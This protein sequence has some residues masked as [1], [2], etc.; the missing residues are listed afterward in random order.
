M[1]SEDR[2]D[3]ARC[4]DEYSMTYRPRPNCEGAKL[5]A[6]HWRILA[7]AIEEA[8]GNDIAHKKSD[9][10]LSLVLKKIGRKD[11]PHWRATLISQKRLTQ[12]RCQR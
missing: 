5:C 1:K 11:D 4:H 7:S 2:C 12:R 6:E 10:K 3:W 9:R 8:D